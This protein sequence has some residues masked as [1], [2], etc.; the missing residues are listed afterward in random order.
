MSRLLGT[1]PRP[2]VLARRLLSRQLGGGDSGALWAV[3][4]ACPS[5]QVFPARMLVRGTKPLC[6]S[7]ISNGGLLFPH[8]VSP[9]NLSLNPDPDTF[10]AVRP[11][12]CSGLPSRLRSSS[13][14]SSSPGTLVTSSSPRSLE[15]SVAI[16]ALETKSRPRMCV[17]LVVRG[18]LLTTSDLFSQDIKMY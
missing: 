12:L 1:R 17:P 7:G 5:R 13:E 2:S 18:R 10:F 14:R 3:A 4:R 8:S 9:T 15:R 11:S 6:L 16:G